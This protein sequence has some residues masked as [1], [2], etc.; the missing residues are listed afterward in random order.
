MNLRFVGSCLKALKGDNV[1]LM[2]LIVLCLFSPDRPNLKQPKLVSVVLCLGIIKQ[3]PLP[4][5]RG[6]TSLFWYD[7]SLLI[8][9]LPRGPAGLR[10]HC[11]KADGCAQFER[12]GCSPKV[13]GI[14][15]QRCS[16]NPWCSQDYPLISC[17]RLLLV[18]TFAGLH[19]NDKKD[20]CKRP[21]TNHS[22]D[23]WTLIVIDR[24]VTQR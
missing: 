2:L 21:G 7:A 22:G 4:G 13:T 5:R 12:G 15:V 8:S 16:F 17:T 20:G 6:A 23:I 19:N 10:A 3:P 14:Q 1:S 24:Y 11:A 9:R 18:P